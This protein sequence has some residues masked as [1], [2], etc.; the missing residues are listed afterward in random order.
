MIQIQ[1]KGVIG[2]SCSSCNPNECPELHCNGTAVQGT[3]CN[4][5]QVC[6]Q[7]ENQQ[8]GGMWGCGGGPCASGLDCVP[9]NYMFQK[10]YTEGNG[11]FYQGTCKPCEDEVKYC[12]EVV[13]SGFCD[14]PFPEFKFYNPGLK[15]RKSC[16]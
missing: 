14:K 13:L 16:G 7:A 12:D 8:C 1:H 4:C 15:C 9:P 10:D 6:G 5:C 2:L 11:K 3:C